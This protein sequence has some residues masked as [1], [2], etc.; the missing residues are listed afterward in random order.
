MRMA[1]ARRSRSTNSPAMGSRGALRD[2]R[3][4]LPCPS[5]LSCARRSQ[6]PSGHTGC[7]ST[8]RQRNEAVTNSPLLPKLATAPPGRPYKAN[9][10]GS[11]PSAPTNSIKQL[12]ALPLTLSAAG[13]SLRDFCGTFAHGWRHPVDSR[14]P[15]RCSRSSRELSDGRASPGDP[16]RTRL[17]RVGAV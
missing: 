4:T 11:S 17:P 14:A 1:P 15:P 16:R 6:R 13:P 12:H 7:R 9:V 8:R 10:G 5:V 3:G 2:S